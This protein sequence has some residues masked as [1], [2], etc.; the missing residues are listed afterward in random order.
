MATVMMYGVS[1]LWLEPEFE[2]SRLAVAAEHAAHAAM[3]DEENGLRAYL[4]T[5]HERFLE[6][7]TKAAIKLERAHNALIAYVGVN[8]ELA[9]R[10]VSTRLAEERWHERWAKAV[11]SPHAGAVAPSM[12]D[13]KALFDAYRGEH[14][15]F[16]NALARHSEDLAEREQRVDAV[17]VTLALAVFLAILVLAARQHGALS[18]AIIVPVASLL[19]HIRGIRDGHLEVTTEHAGSRELAELAEGLN[20]LVRALAAAR[21]LAASRDLAL[22]E[23]SVRLR[24]ILEASREFAESLNLKYVVNAVRESTAVVGGYER[25]IVWLMDDERK[26]LVDS[27]ENAAT[28]SPAGAELQMGQ[29][30]AGRAAKAGRVTFEGPDGELRFND[31]NMGLVRATAIPL[32]VGARVVG[33]LEARHAEARVV[34]REVIEIIEMLA[35]HAATAIESARL[36]AVIEERSHTDV[37]TRLFNRRRL[38]DE[39]DAECK[40]CVRYGRPLSLVMLDV[41]HFKAFNDTHGH[42]QGDTA[43][44][45][46][47]EIIAGCVRTTDTAYRYG[48]EEFVVLMRET[49]AEDAML[50]AE[51]LRVRIEHRFASGGMAGITVSLGVAGFTTDQPT[52]RALLETADAA[53]YESKEAGRN[54]VTLSTRPPPFASASPDPMPAPPLS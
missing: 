37:L 34:T 21:E 9:A 44:Q 25:V 30:L 14:A 24:Q 2:R 32:I 31:S 50:F 35:T 45:E 28:V 15:A 6:P 20:E 18:K 38:D 10:M 7:Y 4:L 12:L 16:A 1:W 48:G 11:A 53:M 33:A 27:D 36:H 41:D 22:R 5:T 29:G 26:R 8:P 3:L 39:L 46:V 42:P 13:G 49:R 47:A 17:R 23:H 40:R 43:L 54:R 19:R 51:R 52:P